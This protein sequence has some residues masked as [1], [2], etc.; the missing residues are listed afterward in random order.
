[1][2]TLAVILMIGLFILI[3]VFI[4]STA[5]LTPLIGKK[6][7]L[8]VIA[9]GFTVGAVGGAFFIAPVFDDIP[10]MA[11]SVY[12]VTT[13]GTDTVGLNVSAKLNVSTFM[14]DTR[15]IDGVQSVQSNGLTLKTSP[16]SEGWIHIFQNRM[17]QINQ[18]II[19][20]KIPSNDTVVIE[21]K[22]NTDPQQVISDLETWMQ[23]V[24]GATVKYS[25]VRVTLEV[26]ARKHD[27]VISQLPMDDVV[28]TDINGPTENNIKTLINIMPKKS[29]VI[30]SCGI[31][32][33]IVGL[34]GLFIDSIINIFNIIKTRILKL[35]K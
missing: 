31:L 20:A 22:N 2:E 33:I 28:I 29:N 32:G 6:N 3:L 15:K 14:E 24:S 21:V 16:L 10:D 35:K 5:L 13:T 11:R 18:N 8:F 34:I 19:Y 7:L 27:K 1:M 4:F 26:D 12:A 9:L 23:Y 30:L 25:I 17:P